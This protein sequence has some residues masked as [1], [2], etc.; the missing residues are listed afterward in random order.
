M[1]DALLLRP[2][3]RRYCVQLITPLPSGGAQL[4]FRSA[5]Q[6]AF[7]HTLCAHWAVCMSSVGSTPSNLN[8]GIM[9]QTQSGNCPP[10]FCPGTGITVGVV[11]PPV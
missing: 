8:R 4:A 10:P 1:Y 9:S 5:I 11:Y 3:V 6:F 7:G 2:G